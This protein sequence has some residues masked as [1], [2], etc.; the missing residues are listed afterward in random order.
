[1]QAI[2]DNMLL[3]FPDFMASPRKGESQ[4]PLPLKSRSFPRPDSPDHSTR[5]QRASTIQNGVKPERII[6][7]EK[8][9]ERETK[10][11]R[12]RLD[13]FKSQ[14]GD[15]LG[16]EVTGKLPADFDQLPIEL[17]SLADRLV[18]AKL[19]QISSEADSILAL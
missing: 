14:D 7:D 5:G 15:R 18:M 3:K 13:A 1:M 8:N 9:S 12:M 16:D 4:R 11:S 10:K 2:T 6:S 17:V 19:H